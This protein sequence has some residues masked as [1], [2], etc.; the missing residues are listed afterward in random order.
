[1]K[2]R[3]GGRR[4]LIILTIL[5]KSIINNSKSQEVTALG[6]IACEGL[7]GLR[8]DLISPSLLI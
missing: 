4:R 2:W 7:R 3:V 8:Y 1:M 6:M 5:R